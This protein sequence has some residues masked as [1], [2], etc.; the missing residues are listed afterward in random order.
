[1]V[2]HPI[3]F[4]LSEQRFF[5]HAEGF[6]FTQRFFF[7]AEARRNI[8]FRESIFSHRGNRGTEVFILKAFSRG[9]AEK[10]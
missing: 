9:G 3:C 2:R 4:T 7:H 8:E 1:M 5:F 6:S 10:F